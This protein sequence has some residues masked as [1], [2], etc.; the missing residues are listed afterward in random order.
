MSD[1]ILIP[2]NA[3]TRQV[4]LKILNV[5]VFDEPEYESIS[6]FFIRATSSGRNLAQAELEGLIP[7]TIAH[8]TQCQSFLTKTNNEDILNP[9]FEKD[10]IR[11][12]FIIGPDIRSI[13]TRR[14]I[15]NS[16]T[17]G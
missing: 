13:R 15:E 1:Q 16:T 7:V 3:E 4:S 12:S 2:F 14:N 8:S 10:Q 6:Q 11:I 9:S 17:E 5:S